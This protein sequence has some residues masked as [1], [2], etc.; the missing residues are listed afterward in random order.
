MADGPS[1]SGAQKIDGL[2]LDAGND[3]L[4]VCKHF[5]EKPDRGF[6]LKRRNLLEG[7]IEGDLHFHI[8]VFD[9]S[10]AKVGKLTFSAVPLRNLIEMKHPNASCI[11]S[12]GSG[13]HSQKAKCSVDFVVAKLV[14]G[15]EGF[16]SSHIRLEAEQIWVEGGGNF[17]ALTPEVV[18]GSALGLSKRELRV[19]RARLSSQSLGC[20]VD[21][22]I[23]AGSEGAQN[24]ERYRDHT[25]GGAFNDLRFE[26]DVPGIKVSLG[27]E[28]V[29][30]AFVEY[31]FCGFKLAQ[32]EVCV[33]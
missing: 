33:R 8:N 22:M 17:R 20:I 15:P 32:P 1:Q 19:F 21:D 5:A 25:E 29:G 11:N 23:E 2:A 6:S 27:K 3:F 31:L 26:K 18:F 7:Y 16:I 12:K 9:P 14:Q 28:S 13:G 4:A 10:G 24:V 30:T